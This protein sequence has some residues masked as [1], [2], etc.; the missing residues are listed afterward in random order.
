MEKLTYEKP[1]LEVEWYDLDNSVEV[2][3]LGYAFDSEWDM[4]GDGSTDA[5]GGED[6]EESCYLSAGVSLASTS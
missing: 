1:D 3:T 4:F 6:W 5:D 2:A